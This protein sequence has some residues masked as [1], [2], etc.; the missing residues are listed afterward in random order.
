[1]NVSTANTSAMPAA[2]APLQQLQVV[3]S[4]AA[5]SKAAAAAPK[6]EYLT[7]E[8][9]GLWKSGTGKQELVAKAAQ[10]GEGIDVM[11]V[12]PVI[13][14]ELVWAGLSGQVSAFEAGQTVKEIVEAHAGTSEIDLESLFLDTVSLMPVLGFADNVLKAI[15]I[16]TGINN[17]KMREQ[18]DLQFLTSL[19]L[20]RENFQKTTTKQ[21]TNLLYRQWNYNLLREESEGYS[22]LITEY[23]TTTNRKPPTRDAVSETFERVMALIG[24]FNLDVGRVLDI[25][26][27]VFANLLVKHYRFFIKFL[28]ISSWWPAKKVYDGIEYETQSFG[29][30]PAWAAPESN[31]WNNT[32]ADRER[33]E[34]QKSARDEKFWDRVR[35]IGVKAF[36]ELGGRRIL[37]GAPEMD[38][39]QPV[40]TKK[41]V[42]GKEV[43]VTEV[44]R[45]D[46]IE[47]IA[48]TRTL[49]PP[50]NPTAAQLLGFKLR[51]YASSARDPHDTLPDNV[52]A[53]AAL[54][55]K[56][57]FIS[58]RD[59]YPH[60]YPG[61]DQMEDVKKRL[62]E[63]KAERERKARPGGGAMNALA[64]AGALSDDTV[65]PSKAHVDAAK[66]A[67]ADVVMAD[68][69]DE[70]AEEQKL[71][72]PADQK[73]MLLKSLLCIG[74][75]SEALF[76]LARFPW[77]MELQPDLLPFFHRILHQSI[78]KVY[79]AIRPLCNRDSIHTTKRSAVDQVGVP[80]GIVRAEQPPPRKVLRW[81]QLEKNDA[82]DGVDYRFYWDDWADNVPVCQNVDDVFTLCGTL[83]NFSGV[84][85][86]H[87]ALLL[88]KLIRIGKA[89][90][91]NDSSEKNMARWA[92]LLK[93]LLVPA[94]SF[95]GDK[96]G[97]VNEIFEL[98]KLYPTP[99]RY[100]IY[101]EWAMGSTS[102]LPEIKS[103]FEQARAE[104]KDILKRISR[105][106]TKQMA[107][108]LAKVAASNP[109]VVFS[110]TI[111]QIESYENMIEVVVECAR[112][113]TFL[114]Y[115]VLT[116]ALMNALGNQGRNRMQQ[117][118]MLT[119]S[120]LRA[121]SM[122][123][124][125]ALRRYS[126]M[127]PTPI[128]QYVAYQV[129]LGNFTDLE[130]LE[131]AVNE[132]TG[133]RS[134]LVLNDSQ[135]QAM[136]GGDLLQSET[137]QRLHDKR[138]MPEVKPSS[139]RLMRSL[140]EMKLAAKLLISIAQEREMYIHRPSVSN[141]PLKVLGNNV[142]QIH[143]LLIQFLEALRTNMT[144]KDFDANVP[145]VASLI[146]DFGISHG[147]AF[148]IARPSISFALAEEDAAKEATK[149]ASSKKDRTQS[150]TSE[151]NAV[152]VNGGD[153]EM[154][155]ADQSTSPEGGEA[156]KQ[157]LQPSNAK[158]QADSE[159][160]EMKDAPAIESSATPTVAPSP[161]PPATTEPTSGVLKSLMD[162]LQPVLSPDFEESMSLSFYATF[163][164]LTLSDLL[165]PTSSYEEEIKRQREKITRVNSERS[166]VTPA[167]A[168]KR[169]AQKKALNDL[170]DKLRAEMKSQIASYSKIRARLG[171]EKE[172]WFSHFPPAKKN[173]VNAAI[174]Q[175][176][177]I[178]RIL[179]SPIDALYTFKMLFYLHS[180]GT[181]GFYTMHLIEYL[182]REKQLT[183]LIYHCSAREVENFGRFLNELLKELRRWHSEAAV[184][185][186]MAF[187][188]KKDLP[189]FVRK[190]HP[191]KTPAEFL[192]YEDF[193]RLLFKWH[194][195]L[196]QALK[197]C[198][199]NTEYM[200]IRNGIIVLKAIHSQF[201]V[202]NFMGRDQLNC[203]D[204]LKDNE[205]RKD[206]K[207]AAYSLYVDIMKQQPK[208]ILPQAF[209][210]NDSTRQQKGGAASRS[211]SA[212]PATPQAS[213]GKPL[214]ANAADF[215]PQTS[216]M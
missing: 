43:E 90:L 96:Y 141:A 119:S 4:P 121:L 27:D 8:I 102:R 184:Y 16:S 125:R 202:V 182:M 25:T 67:K 151:K 38:R 167:A 117:D 198:L 164:Q 211:G 14:Q 80:K 66:A 192:T 123:I 94:V 55:I 62:L 134:D 132:M 199:T 144:P 124:G 215:K 187:G 147:L 23:F 140:S 177:F 12:V 46:D 37:G 170:Q 139:R 168:R 155:D 61:D 18:L 64:M 156:N 191:D 109:T 28:R 111:S 74:A 161:S 129:R 29:A 91:S 75:L 114:A 120:W 183:A 216:A 181:P 178:P 157:T 101:A 89:S 174:L 150:T 30:L 169:E 7:S 126:V 83:L 13:F 84:K 98:L 50:G 189:G 206:L 86:G 103:A 201:P 112:Y 173:M 122:F 138:Y 73:I 87:D 69:E 212:R 70:P 22:K 158:P 79:A 208:W 82:G 92:D 33:V 113:F 145:D 5:M 163:W 2:A 131:H 148:T 162:S 116:W 159:N 40:T 180:S 133:I 176:C 195:E 127:N 209:H 47:W 213:S 21:S 97:V 197:A 166:D 9:L 71:P 93:R 107:R 149:E 39:A 10:S 58:L 11:F 95:V 31:T 49:P 154:T 194:R 85:I 65:D 56:I 24:T 137:L 172:K 153:V 6:F 165:V 118:G 100:N 130:V 42:N 190:F 17:M 171:K 41:M 179:L 200:H 146:A 204:Y 108:A 57:G 53:L 81:A 185:E 143:S 186:K 48:R 36:F 1:M 3:A 34:K 152:A 52:I 35:Q 207:L 78:E 142:D 136:A 54:L 15:L 160:V 115:D 77:L 203:V 105:T 104:T 88:T 175:E 45:E 106:N 63:E 44:L 188:S 210:L 135:T 76:I 20:V 72:G 193:R 214:N 68:A 110:I 19:G 196:N 128:L 32:E 205:K 59:L 60:L 26:L 51:F 99:V